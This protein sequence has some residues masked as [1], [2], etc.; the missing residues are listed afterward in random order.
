MFENKILRIEVNAEQISSFACTLSAIM[1]LYA[2]KS[3]IYSMD[4]ESPEATGLVH[5]YQ[6]EHPEREIDGKK[7][8]VW[9]FLTEEQYEERKE[10]L[11]D[12]CFATRHYIKGL[13]E[14]VKKVHEKTASD[15]EWAYSGLPDLTETPLQHD[16]TATEHANA[17]SSSGTSV[18]AAS[19]L[20][21][22]YS[23]MGGAD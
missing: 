3:E 15:S 10:T 4:P 5:F 2:K 20:Y 6:E 9:K 8:K 16:V 21:Y 11:P 17:A 7:A 19:P 14:T 13:A 12:V 22:A 18:A 23:S 1:F